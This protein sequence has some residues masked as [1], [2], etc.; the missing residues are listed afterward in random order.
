M[1]TT[2]GDE[3]A[4][5]VAIDDVLRNKLCRD[6]DEFGALKGGTKEK[7]NNIEGCEAGVCL[8]IVAIRY[9]RG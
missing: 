9:N 4:E 6:E 8:E 2:I 5:I 3:L 1:D 7:I